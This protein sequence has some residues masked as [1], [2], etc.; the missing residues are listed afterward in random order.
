M[1]HA[2]KRCSWD[3]MGS[4]VLVLQLWST[5]SSFL[6]TRGAESPLV[7]IRHLYEPCHHMTAKKWEFLGTG[8]I[9]Q[10][11]VLVRSLFPVQDN[12]DNGS[13][14]ITSCVMGSGW[15]ILDAQFVWGLPWLPPGMV[16]GFFPKN[17]FQREVN[18]QRLDANFCNNRR[19][20]PPNTLRHILK[21]LARNLADCQILTSSKR[22]NV[23]Q[24]KRK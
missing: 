9:C 7:W 1:S 5:F 23:C 20:V 24:N 13:E 12:E 16:W 21:S 15:H 2:Q 10:P 4:L 11:E 19:H 17:R 14:Y 18:Y 6:H 8:P 22:R 3:S